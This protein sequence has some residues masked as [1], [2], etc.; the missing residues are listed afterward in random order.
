MA[1][2]QSYWSRVYSDLDADI[3]DIE[4]RTGRRVPPDI[5]VDIDRARFRIDAGA[6]GEAI[7]LIERVQERLA[8]LS[9]APARA[10]A[11]G[12]AVGAR[13][14]ANLEALS[15]E[16]TQETRFGSARLE[17]TGEAEEAPPP[18]TRDG[19]AN[20][21]VNRSTAFDD[22]NDEYVQLFETATIRPE[23]RAEV[24][25]MTDKLLANRPAYETIQARTSVPWFFVGLLHAMECSLSFKKHLHNGDSLDGR[26]WQVPAGRPKAGEAP[27]SFE[28]SAIDALEYD[29]FAGKTDWP[30]AMML[31]RME[32]YNGMGYRKKFA[33]ASPYL[34]SFTNHHV[35]GKYVA[36]G[37]WDPTALSKQ[38]GAA[39]MLRDLVDRKVVSFEVAPSPVVATAPPHQPQPQPVPAVAL[40]APVAPQPVPAGAPAVVTAAQPSSTPA[41]APGIAPAATPAATPIPAT[42]AASAPAI[43]AAMPSQAPPSSS[44]IAAVLGAVAAAAAMPK[45]MSPAPV[46]TSPAPA[47]PPQE[48]ETTGT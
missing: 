4:R 11:R 14:Y 6:T 15:A 47:V 38:I 43:V 42:V 20:T 27:F 8:Q 16:L 1:Y 9:G 28:E 17:I 39:V 19:G 23:K 22:I 37:K 30:L 45:P 5:A 44:S 12:A 24:T 13:T 10:I 18:P 7:A 21:K 41:G 46:A 35:R 48:P 29:K 3:S 25:R 26:T 40:S 31:Y 33:I 34:W 32:R 2:D 36:D